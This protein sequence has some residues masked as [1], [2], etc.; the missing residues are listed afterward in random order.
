MRQLGEP[1]KISIFVQYIRIMRYHFAIFVLSV[2]LCNQ[3]SA[4]SDEEKNKRNFMQDQMIVNYGYETFSSN[5]DQA[6][7][8]WYNNGFDIQFFYDYL[9]LESGFSVALGGGFSTQNYFSNSQVRRDETHTGLYSDWVPLDIEYNKNKLA[10]SWLEIPF[11]LRYRTKADKA[12]YQWKATVGAKVGFLID[13]HDK[14]VD[15]DNIKYK[16][17]YFPD[18]NDV[19]FGLIGRI[20]YGRVS[21]ATF[22]SFTEFFVP[23]RGPEMKQISIV[24]SVMPF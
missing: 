13:V 2:L 6:N 5:P 14:W 22:F 1:L 11:E 15:T 23:D 10:A 16:T 9:I 17:Y 19:R 18:I 20:G 4:Q 21:L 8:Q 3:V 24:F 7:F 12:G